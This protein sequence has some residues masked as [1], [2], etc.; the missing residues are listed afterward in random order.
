MEHEIL[1]KMNLFE[2][3]KFDQVTVAKGVIFLSKFDKDEN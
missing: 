1:I 2:G 3:Q